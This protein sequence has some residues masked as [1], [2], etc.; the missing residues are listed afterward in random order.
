MGHTPDLVPVATVSDPMAARVARAMLDS[1]GIEVHS[2]GGGDGPYAVTVG[3]WAGST[4][5]VPEADADD[6]R[7][8]LAGVTGVSLLSGDRLP[9][10]AGAAVRLGALLLAAAVVVAA[11][12]WLAP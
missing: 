11:V 5:A 2:S 9:S 6:A 1:A 3:S 4:L 12:R 8:I 10:A 7:A